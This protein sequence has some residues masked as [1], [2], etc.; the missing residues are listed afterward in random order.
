MRFSRFFIDRPI[1]A[2]VLSIIIVVTGG[3]ALLQLP[4]GALPVAGGRYTKSVPLNLEP[5]HTQTIDYL[6]Y[7]PLPGKFRH[8]P[9][10]VSKN[11]KFVAAAQPLT[12]EVVEKPTKLDT[13]STRSAPS[14]SSAPPHSM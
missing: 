2:A 8:F 11:E 4:V 13:A 6:F 12:F 14:T 7:F 10:H 9:V 3:L 1:L 5:Y